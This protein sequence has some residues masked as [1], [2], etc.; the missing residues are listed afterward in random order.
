[1]VICLMYPIATAGRERRAHYSG[2]TEVMYL[3]VAIG[4]G[5]RSRVWS[6]GHS[7]AGEVVRDERDRSSAGNIRPT[8]RC[9]TRLLP[10]II[11]ALVAV[12]P[13]PRHHL[14]THSSSEQEQNV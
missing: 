13:S 14:K 8:T 1:M 10:S 5:M 2:V 7:G 9:A 6:S 11:V 3:E 4:V 12:A